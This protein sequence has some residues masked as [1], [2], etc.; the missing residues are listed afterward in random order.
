[1][2]TIESYRANGARA[3]NGLG[4]A[5]DQE[6]PI[7]QAP[8]SAADAPASCPMTRTPPRVSATG[9]GQFTIKV[10]LGLLHF[11]GYYTLLKRPGAR[12][13]RIAGFQLTIRPTVY[14]PRYYRAPAY[15]ADFISQLD[16]SGKMVADICTGS[17]IQALAAARAGASA[18]IA[19]DINPNAV[20]AATENARANGFEQRVFPVLSDLFSAVE[21]RPQFDVILSNPPFCDGRA[22]DVADRAWRAGAGYKDIIPLFDQARKRLASDG[23]MYLVLSSYTDLELMESV[24]QRAGF[25]PR[26]IRER[27]V[28]LET[29]VIYELRP[30]PC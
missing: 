23:V 27:R 3:V 24:M 13:A 6:G 25:T 16:L 1:M 26:I 7:R 2:D 11:V 15:F 30:T 19:V 10:V 28:F 18:V 5:T 9:A 12:L 20:A 4:L 22:W 29:L 8:E 14:D 17:G 21:Q